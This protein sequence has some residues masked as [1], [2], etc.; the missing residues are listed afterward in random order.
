[1][2]RGL[3]IFLWVGSLVVL[4]W[5]ILKVNCFD[6]TPLDAIRIFRENRAEFEHIVAAIRE[7]SFPYRRDGQ[8]FAIP[9]VLW[10]S[11]VEYIRWEKGFIAFIFRTGPTC[12]TDRLVFSPEYR[13][14]RPDYG[15]SPHFLEERWYH[16]RTD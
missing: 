5:A 13:S 3:L 4:S 1:M 2:S 11:D 6:S 10:E 12:P 8:G 16:V 9:K 15:T 7:C 14:D